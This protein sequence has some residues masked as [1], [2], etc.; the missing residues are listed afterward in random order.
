MMRMMEIKT[1][2]AI[3]DPGQEELL[4]AEQLREAV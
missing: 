2:R 3:D 4:W 1:G